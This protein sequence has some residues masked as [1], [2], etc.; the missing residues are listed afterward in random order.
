MVEVLS[1][2]E[3]VWKPGTHGN[4]RSGVGVVLSEMQPGSI[5][6]AAAWPGA[7][8]KL[9]AAIKAVT[10]LTLPDGPGRGKAT[11]TKA[12]FGIAPGRFLLSD[13]GEGLAAA[14]SAAITAQIGTVTDLSHGRVALRVAGAKA[15][16]VLAKFFAIDFALE[17]FPL[18]AGRATA[19]H[20]VFAQIQRTGPD[21]FDLYVFRSFARSFWTEL[22][23][24]SEEIGYE[25]S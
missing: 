15:E 11:E 18:G 22:C 25:V 24:A 13:Q 20:D 10:G 16:W 3:P 23:H 4:V 7:E 17:A 1:P 12:A 8:K 5:V 2:L 6:E 19:H 21:Q 9:V 14:L